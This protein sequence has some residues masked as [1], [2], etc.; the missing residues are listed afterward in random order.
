RWGAYPAFW[1]VGGEVIDPPPH[2]TSR[3]EGLSAFGIEATPGWTEVA[4]YIRS[5]DPVHHPLSV[6]EWVP[7]GDLPLQDESLMDFDLFQ[8]AHFGWPSVALDVAQRDLHYARTS[9]RKPE[10]QGEMTYETLGTMDF[11]DVQRAGFWLS[12]LNGAAG[13][14]YGTIETAEA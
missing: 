2:M 10:V 4:R 1:L 3:L 13:H 14:T 8:G 6:H 12:M 5:T 9:V 11:E 7:P